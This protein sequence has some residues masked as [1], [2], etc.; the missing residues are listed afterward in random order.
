[1]NYRRLTSIYNDV[2]E[3]TVRDLQQKEE[4]HG[5][6]NLHCGTYLQN[7]ENHF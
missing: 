5:T 3:G 2:R 6:V 7:I 4:H 1:M